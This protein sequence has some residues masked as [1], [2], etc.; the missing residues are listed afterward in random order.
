M[1]HEDEI[2]TY[3]SPDK[4]STDHRMF[5]CLIPGVFLL[6][7]SALAPILS[8]AASPVGKALGELWEGS[9]RAGSERSFGDSEAQGGSKKV[10][11]GL[12]L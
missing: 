1:C 2:H 10:W 12:P 11:E 7:T 6:C 3:T 8:I 9:G 4:P 5:I